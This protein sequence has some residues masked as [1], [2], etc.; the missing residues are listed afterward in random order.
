[1]LS[2]PC[3]THDARVDKFKKLEE[4]ALHGLHFDDDDEY[5]YMQHLKPRGAPGAEVLAVPEPQGRK[6]QTAEDLLGA[7]EAGDAEEA[8]VATEKKPVALPSEVRRVL[9]TQLTAVRSCRQHVKRQ[10]ACSHFKPR[11][12]GHNHSGTRMWY[13]CDCSKSHTH[14]ESTADCCFG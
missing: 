3:L 11:S 6:K 5:D 14:L 12:A 4:Q 8:E 10:L 9:C 13:V 1:M 7:L 2:L